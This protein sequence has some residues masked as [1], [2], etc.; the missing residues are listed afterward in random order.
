[1]PTKAQLESALRNADKAGDVQAAKALAN[2]LKNNQ[3][4]DYDKQG[5]ISQSASEA[6]QE[7]T[8]ALDAIGSGFIRGFEQ[9]TG[10]M[11]QRSV[12]FNK[13]QTDE[14]IT[15][16][17][18]GMQTGSIPVTQENL[19]L[20]DRL[21]MRSIKYAK[22]LSSAENIESQKRQ[23][24]SPV[25]EERPVSSFVG[26]IAGQMA[27]LPIPGAQFKLPAQMVKGAAEGALSGYTQA[28]VGD[29][30]PTDSAQEG[31]IIGGAA[32]AVLRPIAQ[33]V[34]A[35]YR[36]IKGRITGE[37]ADVI[38]YASRNELPLMTSDV[39]PPTTFA[40]RSAQT[41]SEKIPVVGTASARADQQAARTQ[42][43]KALSDQYGVPSDE[44]IFRSIK[45]KGNRISGAAGKRY[46]NIIEQMGNDSIPLDR[47][48]RVIDSQ[49][50]KYSAPGSISNPKLIET[51]R[52][53]KSDLTSG[54]QDISLLRQNRTL[55]RER[56][57]G[58]S[59]SVSD[60][61]QRVI[62]SVYKAITE[63]M[64]NGVSAKIGP[65]AAARMR[66]A[67]AVWA[68]EANEVK[69]TKLKNI[70]NKGDIKP[71]EAS[72]MLFS[73]DKSEISTLYSALDK[74]GRKNARAAVIQRAY[75]RSG[76][77]PDQFINEMKK[78]RRQSSVF[79]RGREGKELNGLIN[80]LD[81]TRQAGKAPVMTATG[82]QVLS[83]G[84]PVGIVADIQA[85]GG[86]GTGA[87]ASIGLLSRA[88][89]SA[90]VRDIMARMATI[91]KGST[92]FEKLSSRLE[93][94][95]EKA[96]SRISNT[97]NS[98]SEE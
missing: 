28:T 2:A 5:Y 73:N 58:D 16:L 10:G 70:L 13:K 92:P 91:E 64:V 45:D 63:D 93:S 9:Q 75:D 40:G 74:N 26:N 25:S 22:D 29:E 35:A 59:V 87:L 52:G 82:Q 54:P 49:I 71:E 90:P 3:Y 24:Y 69:K 89:E 84:A 97:D 20:L 85:T 77:S 33:A 48:I 55:F 38:D 57:K 37:N 68:R 67:D 80:Y 96:S 65:D 32:P 39:I 34:G 56:I 98:Q 62:D 66:Q 41:I 4:D 11:V 88:Y 53:V 7:Q 78:L 17:A 76:G 79:F 60:T 42:K 47:T 1:M 23:N 51:L 14:R 12:E 86:V 21:Q 18:D 72:K 43:V 15:E 6:T 44:E 50:A 8:G 31:A 30:L 27:G 95:L 19:D 83:V 61:E 94:E 81:Y 36:G 46:N